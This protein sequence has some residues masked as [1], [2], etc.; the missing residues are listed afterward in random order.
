MTV[1]HRLLEPEPPPEGPGYEG[2]LYQQMRSARPLHP[3]YVSGRVT[4][5]KESTS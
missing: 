2:A 1:A 3:I 4:T 5:E